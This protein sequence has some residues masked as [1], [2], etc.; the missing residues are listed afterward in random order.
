MRPVA[1]LCATAA[2]L[3]QLPATA[4]AEPPVMIVG[5]PLTVRELPRAAEKTPLP[6]VTPSPM[7]RAAAPVTAAFGWT[8][9][10]PAGEIVL[11]QGGFAQGL[12]VADAPG[13]GTSAV[14]LA[15]RGAQEG[16][17]WTQKA[18]V[19]RQNAQWLLGEFNLTGE[20]QGHTHLAVGDEPVIA[21]PLLVEPLPLRGV[22]AALSP[23]G[24]DTRLYLGEDRPVLN[25]ATAART[26]AGLEAAWQLAGLPLR[27]R[28]V[29]HEATE[30]ERWTSAASLGSTVDWLGARLGGELAASAAAG[31]GDTAW[32]L[33]AQ[34]PLGPSAL[35]ATFV[36]MGPHFQPVRHLNL[37]QEG[38]RESWQATW[39][40]PLGPAWRAHAQFLDTKSNLGGQPEAPRQ[41]QRMGMAGLM[42]APEQGPSASMSYGRTHFR[43]DAPAYAYASDH[44]RLSSE[45]RFRLPFA[46]QSRLAW[47]WWNNA[48]AGGASSA[49][50]WALQSGRLFQTPFSFSEALTL[51]PGATMRIGHG[52]G[53]EGSWPKSRFQADAR[54]FYDHPL[55][56]P[57][58]P[59]SQLRLTMGLS[60]S[61]SPLDSMNL[62]G[63][64]DR[65]LDGQLASARWGLYY[66]TRFGGGTR[67]AASGPA[68]RIAGRVLLAPDTPPL[69]ADCLTAV[70]DRVQRVALDAEGRFAFEHL[71]PGPHTVELDTARLP[72]AFAI[73]RTRLT[74]PVTLAPEQALTDVTFVVG[75]SHRVS[76]RVTLPSG[77]P[78][79]FMGLALEGEEP[80]ETWT[81]DEGRF[82]FEGV[83]AGQVRVRLTSAPPGADYTWDPGE[84]VVELAGGKSPAALAFTVM[85]RPR[86]VHKVTL[87]LDADA[88]GLSPQPS[89]P[90][91]AIARVAGGHAV[92]VTAAPAERMTL[93]FGRGP[94]QALTRQPDGTWQLRLARL[95]AMPGG[96][97][98]AELRTTR[99]GHTRVTPLK[100]AAPPAARPTGARPAT[101]GR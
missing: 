91:A 80:M 16:V 52:L 49:H 4:S 54:A 38:G 35:A 22:H 57:A 70:L 10:V 46:T 64:V 68:A 3:A 98:S 94:W 101:R 15:M 17:R 77:R 13:I 60:A 24:V 18:T 83:P 82:V 20:F 7:L 9:A 85:E 27:A 41:A 63:Q 34:V 42:W 6:S 28:G 86:M 48:Q 55:D 32:T 90:S 100:L 14:G 61:I 62:T 97:L 45:V 93:R 59:S 25:N 47:E 66:T 23:G 33:D 75:P 11:Q 95:P 71:S 78:V 39:A 37:P 88:F 21:G 96:Y 31:P 74:H 40:M 8:Q 43:S 69:P 58:D 84:T 26:T 53:W 36:R 30:G 67:A 79:G 89:A 73:A 81:D 12:G 50:Q 87:P 2:A 1:L 76:G 51:S 65:R 99:A 19:D 92:T 5:E 44:H 72:L 56:A 29:L